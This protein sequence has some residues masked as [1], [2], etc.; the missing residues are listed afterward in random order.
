MIKK[1]SFFKWVKI[2]RKSFESIKQEI[3]DAPSLSTPIFL[4]EI[5]LYTFSPEKSYVVVLTQPNEQQLEALISLF[6][7]NLQ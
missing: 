5:V 6:S 1:K 2:E 7:S 4:K 3:I